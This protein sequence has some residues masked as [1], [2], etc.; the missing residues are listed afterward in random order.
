MALDYPTKLEAAL[1]YDRKTAVDLDRVLA[2][3]NAAIADTGIAFRAGAVM[4][5]G[6]TRA[7]V[8]EDFF[9]LISQNPQPLGPEGFRG[10]L[11]SN[12]VHFVMPDAV[13]AVSEH[14]ANLFISLSLGVPIPPDLVEGN[15]AMR[16][17]LE[18]A[19]PP[20]T[21]ED[22]D[23]F[24]LMARFL[25][26]MMGEVCNADC[27]RA[28]H[29]MQS[30][31]LLTGDLAHKL[32]NEIGLVHLLYRPD[33]NIGRDINGQQVASVITRGARHLIGCEIN[34]DAAPVSPEDML[35]W[36]HAFIMMS[37]STVIPDRDTFGT[38]DLR[39]RVNYGPDPSLPGGGVVRLVLEYRKDPPFGKPW[40]GNRPPS[41]GDVVSHEDDRSLLNRSDL[42]RTVAERASANLVRNMRSRMSETSRPEPKPSGKS[43]FGR[44]RS[45]FG[46][47]H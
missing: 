25:M 26:T 40:P 44:L 45:A 35:Q 15:P 4:G 18:L 17:I 32:C 33:I 7:F 21:T 19:A 30:N 37:L 29:W 10:A 46:T 13:R 36:V 41:G 3:F 27:P 38:E 8:Y 34:F 9:F 6:Q 20:A 24:M 16:A 5:G 1:L 12:F 2:R 23:V 47:R 28:V 22:Q 14:K 11:A 42:N 31:Q 39:I 43:L